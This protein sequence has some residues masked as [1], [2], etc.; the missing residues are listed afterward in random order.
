MEITHAMATPYEVELKRLHST[1]SPMP[2]N[3]KAATHAPETGSRNWRHKFD[4]RFR[5]QF[6]VPIASGTKKTVADLWHQNL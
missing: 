3:L 1:T 2:G 4:A 6:F 5:C